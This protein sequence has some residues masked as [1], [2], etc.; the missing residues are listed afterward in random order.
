MSNFKFQISNK[1]KV[2]WLFG[3][4]NSRRWQAGF[5]IIELIV[6]FSIMAILATLSFASLSGYQRAQELE[7]ATSQVITI[8][9]LAKSRALS[10]VK[11]PECSETALDGYQFTVSSNK[12]YSLSAVCAGTLVPVSA[13]MLPVNVVFGTPPPVNFRFTVLGNGVIGA[14]A[15]GTELVVNGNGKTKTITV[16]S[17][18]RIV[19]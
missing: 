4:G 6:S 5:T 19:Y 16:Y 15:G 9:K 8:M 13:Y 10:Q 14:D 17:N 18:G 11:P 2:H 7:T 1:N 12:D 3:I